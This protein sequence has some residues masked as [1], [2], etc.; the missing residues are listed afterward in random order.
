MHFPH[1]VH[2]PSEN[3]PSFAGMATPSGHSRAQAWHSTHLEGNIPIC[4]RRSC[5]SGFAHQGQFNGQPFKKTT[6]R[7][8]GP[9][10]TDQRWIS[11]TIFFIL[12]D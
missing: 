7:V 9:S 10:D 2:I 3:A 11:M 4:G 1:W 6:V 12:N 5:D 8:P